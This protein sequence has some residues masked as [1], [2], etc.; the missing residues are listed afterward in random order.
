MTSYL[1]DEKAIHDYYKKEVFTDPKRLD[2]LKIS[3]ERNSCPPA[4]TSEDELLSGLI[5]KFSSKFKNFEVANFSSGK[6]IEMNKLKK[7]QYNVFN[8]VKNEV[9]LIILLDKKVRERLTDKNDAHL[10]HGFVWYEKTAGDI[11]K[12]VNM[13]FYYVIY[14][15]TEDKSRISNYKN[16]LFKS[17]RDI[18]FPMEKEAT[19]F[20]TIYSFRPKIHPEKEWPEHIFKFASLKLH[21]RFGFSKKSVNITFHLIDKSHCQDAYSTLINSYFTQ[22]EEV[23]NVRHIPR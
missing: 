1:E 13:D 5:G 23:E 18:P 17:L 22:I 8:R 4:R 16:T 9:D 10:K 12:N 20:Q 7:L 3:L 15:K 21:T 2:A 14:P 11:W 19:K 6:V